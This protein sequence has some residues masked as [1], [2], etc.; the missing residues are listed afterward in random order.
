MSEFLLGIILTVSLIVLVLSGLFFGY[1]YYTIYKKT[2]KAL[3]ED[4][5]AYEET[6]RWIEK[7]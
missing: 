7:L 3:E 1:I 2:N 5:A 6:R 4:K